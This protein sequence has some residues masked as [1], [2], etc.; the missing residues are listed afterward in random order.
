MDSDAEDD[1]IGLWLLNGIHKIF[2][3]L[4][5]PLSGTVVLFDI[6]IFNVKC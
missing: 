3:F 5:S 4:L 6:V 2:M 1:N